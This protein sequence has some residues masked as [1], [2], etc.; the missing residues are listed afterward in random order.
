VLALLFLWGCG[1]EQSSAQKD[2]AQNSEELSQLRRLYYPYD[3]TQYVGTLTKPSGGVEEVALNLNYSEPQV[4]NPGRNATTGTPT[5]TGTFKICM[6]QTPCDYTDNFTN[7][8]GSDSITLT[9]GSRS[10]SSNDLFLYIAGNCPSGGCNG[11]SGPTSVSRNIDLIPQDDKNRTLKGKYNDAGG[12]YD[13]I[14]TR[15]N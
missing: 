7:A 14:L 9:S 1:P 3:R 12:V 5:L 10:T 8:N 4:S 6:L 15:I 2:E 13:L 11:V